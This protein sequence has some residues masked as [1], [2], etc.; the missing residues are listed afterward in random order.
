MKHLGRL[1]LL[2]FTL[3]LHASVVGEDVGNHEFIGRPRST[4]T[5][6]THPKVEDKS[7][8]SDSERSPRALSEFEDCGN[9]EFPKMQ[10][11]RRYFSKW[12]IRDDVSF[13]PAVGSERGAECQLVIGQSDNTVSA[14]VVPYKF[15]RAHSS[16]TVLDG[17][18]IGEGPGK[19]LIDPLSDPTLP[20]K[21]LPAPCEVQKGTATGVGFNTLPTRGEEGVAVRTSA[22]TPDV[23]L[24]RADP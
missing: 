14:M 13:R 3:G 9:R 4:Q 19:F 6:R 24:V 7:M 8:A 1:G 20:P 18:D 17:K 15:S 22:P 21:F 12:V 10:D 23:G 16:A 11:Q 2:A 5:D